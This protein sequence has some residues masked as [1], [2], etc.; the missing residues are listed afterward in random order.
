[1]DLEHLRFQDKF[2]YE[3]LIDDALDTEVVLVPNMLIQPHLE[4]AIWHGLRYRETKGLLLLKFELNRGE[5]SVI[6]DDNGIG[7]TQSAEL[8]TRN[9]KVHQSRGVT[10]TKERI[11]LLNELYKT[12]ISFSIT[13][14]NSG[15][16][17]TVVKIVFPKIEKV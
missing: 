1:M 6:V 3:I 4:N 9:Q 5:I 14:K 8:K 11:N 16:T 7:L 17:G 12:N 2:D 13:E 10:N 15:E